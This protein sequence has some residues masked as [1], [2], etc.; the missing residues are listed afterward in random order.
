M[1]CN[2]RSLLLTDRTTVH[3]FGFGAPYRG[4][5]HFDEIFPELAFDAHFPDFA[6]L[7]SIRQANTKLMSEHF[8][9]FARYSRLRSYDGLSIGVIR[10]AEEYLPILNVLRRL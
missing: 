1:H 10:A 9:V 3:L 2:F 6:L 4:S 5:T 7:L 8:D